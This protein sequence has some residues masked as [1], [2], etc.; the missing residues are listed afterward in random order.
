M[1]G[2]QTAYAC[3]IVGAL[4]DMTFF[5]R[6]VGA[7][8]DFNHRFVSVK[9][10][11]RRSVPPSVQCFTAPLSICPRSEALTPEIPKKTTPSI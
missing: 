11:T 8:R 3:D 10:F 9:L 5:I 1:V 7:L 6:K 2:K 4:L